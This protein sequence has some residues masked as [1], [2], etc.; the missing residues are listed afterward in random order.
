MPT[1]M[2]RMWPFREAGESVDGEEPAFHDGQ[3]RRVIAS[4]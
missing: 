1:V 2:L 3:S 4:M